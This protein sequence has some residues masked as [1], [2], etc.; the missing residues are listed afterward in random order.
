[1][2][3][4]L[5]RW[6][7]NI[8]LEL[9]SFENEMLKRT[10]RVPKYKALYQNQGSLSQCRYSLGSSDSLLPSHVSTH[11]TFAIPSQLRTYAR[12]PC[13]KCVYACSVTQS[14]PALC[15]PMDCSP[16]GS[17]VLGIFQARILEWVC[18]FLLQGIFPSQGSNPYLLHGQVDSLPLSHLGRPNALH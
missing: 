2:W 1:M 15:N 9:A 7:Q 17:S 11:S 12:E 4:G 6:P 16:P 5:R 3:Q 18:H 14:C 13:T 10:N 8:F